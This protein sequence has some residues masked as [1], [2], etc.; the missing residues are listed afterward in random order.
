ML[1]R[2]PATQASR[3]VRIRHEGGMA[4]ITVIGIAGVLAILTTT[5]A[6]RSVNDLKQ[7]GRQ[8]RFEQALHAAE[9]GIDH[10]MF[11]ISKDKNYSNASSLPAFASRVEERQWALS[12]AASLPTVTTNEGEW[13]AVK[14]AGAAIIYSVGY[15]PSRTTPDRTR[16]VRAEYD[17]P[18]YRPTGAIMTD[19]RLSIPGDP[20]IRGEAG[21][22]HTNDDL[23]ISGD[24]TFSG[25]ATAAG[26]Y[27]VGG[28]AVFCSPSGEVPDCDPADSGG[29]APSTTIPDVHPRDNYYMSE[30]DLCPDGKVRAGPS[31][32]AGGAT[33]NST[34]TPCQ[35]GQLATATSN[36][37]RGWK[38]TGTDSGNKAALW[39]YVTDSAYDGVYYIYQGSGK[40]GSNPGSPSNPMRVTLLA[41]SSPYPG[42]EPHCPHVGGDIE[43]SGNPYFQY[44]DKAHPLL[45]V[46]G[47]DLKLNGNPEAGAFDYQ[48]VMMAHEQIQ[49]SGNPVVTGAFIADDACDSSNSPIHFNELNGNPTITYNG[50]FEIPV[51]E[52][53]RVTHWLEL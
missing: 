11:K 41:E 40:L 44:H 5:I 46:A 39:D 30:Y 43:I 17:F 26:N 35:G 10:A 51:G 33:P 12:A 21:H 15:I 28:S 53:I 38:M 23:S 42:S 4:L 18:T 48:G 49:I 50:D 7:S 32:S 2:R 22:V 16:V 45:L 1:R 3:W 25:N 8:R 36:A 52:G 24:P 29:G 6:V 9:S 34:T 14:P 13:V 19:G 47:R 31:Y 20:V 27:S 37:Y